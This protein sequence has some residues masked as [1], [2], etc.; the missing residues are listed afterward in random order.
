MHPSCK[1]QRGA[2][3]GA[4]QEPFSLPVQPNTPKPVPAPKM[5]RRK[6]K[7][8]SKQSIN[9]TSSSSEHKGEDDDEY[10]PEL[11]MTQKQLDEIRGTR[12]KR[13]ARKTSGTKRGAAKK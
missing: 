4:I 8:K 2:F 9:A 11:G 3:S 12:P 6:D 10:L 5:S 1:I 13:A 7:G